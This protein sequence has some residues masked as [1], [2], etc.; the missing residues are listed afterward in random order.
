MHAA[1]RAALS[2]QKPGVIQLT[3]GYHQLEGKKVPLKKPV[4]ILDKVAGSDGTRYQARAVALNRRRLIPALVWHCD[5]LFYELVA[6][7]LAAVLR[8]AV[9]G[10]A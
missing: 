1:S 8:L 3:I 6:A 2:S 5:C 10:E 9:G 7:P 4:A